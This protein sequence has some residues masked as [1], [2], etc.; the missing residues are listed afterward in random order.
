MLRHWLFKC[1]FKIISNV[2]KKHL[3]CNCVIMYWDPW[4]GHMQKKN[5]SF[6]DIFCSEVHFRIFVKCAAV[7]P[8]HKPQQPSLRSTDS[9]DRKD[10][11]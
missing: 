4:H 2:S 3:Q 8:G 6:K 11:S 9:Q 10:I 1:F 5:A 7:I